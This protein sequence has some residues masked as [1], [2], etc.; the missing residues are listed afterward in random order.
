VD[1]DE[2]EDEEAGVVGEA[3]G[4]IGD[5]VGGLDITSVSICNI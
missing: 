5:K 1:E 4:D 2:D 3:V